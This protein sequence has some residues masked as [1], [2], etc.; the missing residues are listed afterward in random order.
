MNRLHLDFS[1]ES[2]KERKDFLDKYLLQ[3]QFTKI[4]LTNEELET[5]ANYILWGKDSDGKNPVQ[6]KEIQIETKNKT[7]NK[8]QDEESLDALL[9]TPTFNESL[10]KENTEAR[11]KISKETFSRKEALEKAPDFL[12]ETFKNLFYEIDR[13]DLMLNFYDLRVGKRKQPPRAELLKTFSPKDVDAL[14]IKGESLT[15]YKY[16]KLRHQLVELR[17]QQYTLKD[18]YSTTIQRETLPLVQLPQGPLVF[19]SDVAVF[20]LGLYIGKDKSYSFFRTKDELNPT[21]FSE[22]DLE[23]ISKIFWDRTQ[24]RTPITIDFRELEHVYGLLLML[25]DL[26]DAA[27]DASIESTTSLLLETLEFYIRFA[28]LDEVQS[29][30][31]DFKIRKVKNQDIADFINEKYGKTYTANYISTI[32]R[33]KIIRKINEAA[34][35]HEKI[36]SNLF[37]QENFKQCSSC[38]KWI[39][40]DANNFI[41]KSRAKDGLSNRCKVCD[42]KARL[43]NKIGGM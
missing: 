32:F 30:I 18:S 21:V 7:W 25:D 9:E 39:L 19:D 28:E 23:V 2:N 31:L 5:C 15:Q 27:T 42:K 34:E 12:K 36:V 26:R 13:L 8:T 40:R 16:L 33:Q 3:E 11:P 37:F 1:L 22:K 4:P 43:K 10:I 41:R 14:R 17:R 38:K 29:E 20:P 6:K 35:M 24:S